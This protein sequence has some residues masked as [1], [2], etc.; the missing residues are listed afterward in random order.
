MIPCLCSC[1]RHLC[2]D[3]KVIASFGFLTSDFAGAIPGGAAAVVEGLR[4]RLGTL[5]GELVELLRFLWRRAIFLVFAGE[6][7][8][9][10]GNPE[11]PVLFQCPRFLK[12]ARKLTRGAG[13]P[14]GDLDASEWMGRSATPRPLM[15][16]SAEQESQAEGLVWDALLHHATTQ[17]GAQVSTLEDDVELFLNTS[18]NT[19]RRRG[20]SVRI[21]GKAALRVLLLATH[22]AK[23]AWQAE[24]EGSN[25][26]GIS[27]APTSHHSVVTRRWLHQS[28]IIHI[29]SKPYVCVE[30]PVNH[31]LC[32]HCSA[33][34]VGC[35]TA[36]GG[37]RVPA[38]ERG[39]APRHVPG[40]C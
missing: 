22:E 2:P 6:H 11:K 7:T 18:G 35:R 39:A 29:Q 25:D 8:A 34:C 24:Q 40:V 1:K 9:T 38:A 3:N 31:K 17:Q 33:R 10:D 12:A 19:K 26:T 36:Y 14:E 13:S 32:V 28:L 15:N 21:G 4:H 30:P 23:A 5:K 27:S 20:L 37:S 16:I